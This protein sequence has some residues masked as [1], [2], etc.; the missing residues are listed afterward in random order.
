VREELASYSESLAGKTEILVPTK[1]DVTEAETVLETFRGEVERPLFP[2]SAVSGRGLEA[3][4]GA[5][6]SHL[7]AP[8]QVS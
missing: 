8:D 6:A 4:L 7:F 2:I 1:M 5:I 3:L